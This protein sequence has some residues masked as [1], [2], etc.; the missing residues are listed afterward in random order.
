MDLPVISAPI[1]SQVSGSSGLSMGGA[2]NH[3]EG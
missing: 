3:E 2:S 1:Y